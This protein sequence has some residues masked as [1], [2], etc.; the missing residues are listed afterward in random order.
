MIINV[1]DN[2]KEIIEHIDYD[3]ISPEEIKQ[4]LEMAIEDLENIESEHDEYEGYLEED[5]Y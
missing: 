4:K 3:E 1:I 5:E 2:L